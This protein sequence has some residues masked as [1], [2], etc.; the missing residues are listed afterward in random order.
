MIIKFRQNLKITQMF[1]KLKFKN[2]N[3]PTIIIKL[4]KKILIYYLYH[5]VQYRREAKNLMI[6]RMMI[7]NRITIKCKKN[8]KI[9]MFYFKFQMKIL[10]KI[11]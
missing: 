5:Q 4:S 2:L 6:N 1:L 11:Q 3:F 7:I 10:M 9:W 8:N